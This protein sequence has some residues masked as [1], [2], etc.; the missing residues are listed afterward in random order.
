MNHL[1]KAVLLMGVFVFLWAAVEVLGTYAGVPATEIVWFR[2]GTHLIVMLIVF[3]PRYGASMIRTKC[4]LG[5]HIV[6]SLMMLGMPVSYVAAAGRMPGSDMLVVFWIYPVMLLAASHVLGS[7]RPKLSDYVMATVCV[8]GAM[9]I[10]H[11]HTSVIR[12]ASV[13]PLAMAGFLVAYMLMTRNMVDESTVTNLFHTALWVFAALTPHMLFVW[14]TPSM[15]GALAM[16]AIGIFG[17]AG[18]YALDKAIHLA[19]PAAFASAGF[20]QL[21]FT[22]LIDAAVYARIP[23]WGRTIGAMLIVTALIAALL[24]AAPERKAVGAAA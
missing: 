4:P 6:R 7:Y 2:Y 5:M 9:L 21:V 12:A 18:L 1:G 10:L 20:A 19:A 22:V 13:L 11:P 17:L 16:A 14:H 8:A 24:A 23:T 15:R 3:G